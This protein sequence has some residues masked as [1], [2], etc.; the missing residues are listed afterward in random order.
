L[1]GGIGTDALCVFASLRALL[2]FSRAEAQRRKGIARSLRLSAAGIV[3]ASW[4]FFFFR[5]KAEGILHPFLQKRTFFLSKNKKAD[6]LWRIGFPLQ[7]H[8]T[9][10][11]IE[12]K[13][14]AE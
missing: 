12:V 9:D 8:K 5:R 6:P 14:R 3:F 7:S 11:Y 10:S 13:C 4:Y 2:F 1:Q